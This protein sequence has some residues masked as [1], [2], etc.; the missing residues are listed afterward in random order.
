MVPED[1]RIGTEES[2]VRG[3]LIISFDGPQFHYVIRSLLQTRPRVCRR[4]LGSSTLYHGETLG[5]GMVYCWTGSR[6]VRDLEVW[7][8]RDD[9]K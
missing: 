2:G 9:C 5:L 8:P 6:V 7:G 4:T 3:T 1:V